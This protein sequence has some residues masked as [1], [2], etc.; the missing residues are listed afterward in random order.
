MNTINYIAGIIATLLLMAADVHSQNP[1]YTLA[2]TNRSADSGIINSLEWDIDMTWTNAG[3]APNF[4]YAGGQYFFNVD[5]LVANNGILTY[6]IVGSD[7]PANLI[8]RGPS[9][10]RNTSTS[11]GPMG[12]Y[13]LRLAINTFPGA[14]SGFNLPP[15]SPVTIARVRIQTTAQ[16]FAPV[17][18]NLQW[19]NA[20]PN[21]FTKIF[22][23]VGLINTDIT[24]PATHNITFSNNPLPTAVIVDF[25]SDKDTVGIGETINFTDQSIG[26]PT[27]WSW[28][29]PGGTPSSSIARNPVGIRYFTPGT[30]PVT[31]IASNANYRDTLTKNNYIIVQSSICVPVWQATMKITDNG[32]T[33]DSLIFG[34][35]NQGT[36]SIDVCLGEQILPPPPPVGIFDIRFFITP[37]NEE[38]KKDFR[39][40]TTGN[41]SWTIKFQPSSSG[42]PVTF[43]WNP[44]ALP[45]SGFF[46]LKD[47]VTGNIININMRNQSSYVL[48]NTGIA[49]LRIEYVYKS[50]YSVIIKNGWNMTSVPL[51]AEN[52]GV[53]TLFNG[54]QIPVY[55]YN[56]GYVTASTLQN[57]K[58]YW[59]K[60]SRDTSYN[61]LGIPVFP[62]Q[63]NITAGWNMIGPLD[64]NIP[65]SQVVQNPPGIISS[66]YYGYANGYVIADT[67]KSG[68]GYWVKSTSPGTLTRFIADNN[69]PLASSVS[70]L[71]NMIRII[72][73]TSDEQSADLYLANGNEMSGDYSL[74]PVPPSGIY[75]VRFSSDNLVEAI[76]SLHNIRINSANGPFKIKL[77]NARGL[78]FRIKDAVDGSLLNVILKDGESI[79]VNQQL[80]EIIL[81]EDVLIPKEFRLS[82]NYPNPFNPVT[83]IEYAIPKDV[84]VKLNVYDIL[85]RMV[86]SLVDKK[87]TAGN[88]SVL[89]DSHS[90]SS[91]TYFYRIV[92]GDF[93]EMKKLVILK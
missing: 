91:G 27:S 31:L 66:S 23:Y 77:T 35:S 59:M 13:Q 32:N 36:A 76:G 87:L 89:F 30:Y 84:H 47:A 55:G 45:A 34:T 69:E 2:C 8:P 48:T 41:H 86:T 90:L 46:Y 64:E 26:S 4:E 15:G 40:D 18:M 63:I 14:G 49:S 62:K 70:N 67:L 20:L 12:T 88:Y 11:S 81:I 72:F 33:T 80:N 24:T 54:V 92:A 43:N 73:S 71:D 5:T 37:S 6:S 44:S 21:P 60:F 83:T 74:P 42:Y 1:A 19:R 82:Q 51:L 56:G 85:G 16:S 57:G 75:D 58:S 22:A 50:T 10:F 78:Q 68:K 53:S 7:L 38:T 29:F 25:T 79:E 17:P 61:I 52:M 65:L 93:N 9:V 39:K 3:A 28:Q